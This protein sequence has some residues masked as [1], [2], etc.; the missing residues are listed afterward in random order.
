MGRKDGAAG[1]H[2][3]AEKDIGHNDVETWVSWDH[4]PICAVIRENE[5]SN[6]F[7]ERREKEKWT[8]MEATK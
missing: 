5:T 2:R 6:Y 3:W 7:P 1:L 8:G 4:Y